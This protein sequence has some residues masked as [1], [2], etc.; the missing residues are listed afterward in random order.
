M[1]AKYGCTEYFSLKNLKPFHDEPILFVV[2]HVSILKIV[3]LDLTN[4]SCL[5]SCF[6][7]LSYLFKGYPITRILEY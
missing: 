4:S 6:I 2:S 7:W 5:I 1:V 3:L